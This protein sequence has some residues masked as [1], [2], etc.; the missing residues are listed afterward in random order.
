MNAGRE[1]L[2]DAGRKGTVSQV[3]EPMTFDDFLKPALGFG[4]LSLLVMPF[5]S[6]LLR[7]AGFRYA[8]DGCRR[9]IA[10]AHAIRGAMTPDERR[11]P[12]LRLPPERRAEIAAQARVSAGDVEG[13]M[14][15]FDAS[16]RLM[17]GEPPFRA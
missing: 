2:A 15:Q 11:R 12:D 9:E 7:A 16:R 3:G 14:E 6:L 17:R 5:L 10:K 1:D 8:M 4:R 13:F